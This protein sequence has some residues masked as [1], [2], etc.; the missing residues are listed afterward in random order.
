MVAGDWERTVGGNRP[1]MFSEEG[2]EYHEWRIRFIA[3]L[4]VQAGA[5][6]DDGMDWDGGRA[7][8]RPSQIM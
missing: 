4:S 5:E 1:N 6:I 2:S 7:R 3:F 8:R